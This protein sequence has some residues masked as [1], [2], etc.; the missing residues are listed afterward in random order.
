MEFDIWRLARL[1][2]DDGRLAHANQVG[3]SIGRHIILKLAK[4]PHFA[5][6]CL[7]NSL[8]PNGQGAGIP[9]R[10][11]GLRPC[12][13]WLANPTP[14][15]CVLNEQA[16]VR[17]SGL[18]QMTIAQSQRQSDRHRRHQHGNALSKQQRAHQGH[19]APVSFRE[20]IL[21]LVALCTLKADSV[22]CT[23]SVW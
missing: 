2:F 11:S 19:L 14:N 4:A 22:I 16:G 21:H 7:G 8:I 18:A 9:S 20:R 3:Q 5:A 6:E 13:F 12:S 15:G 17:P 23:S 1:D 10:P